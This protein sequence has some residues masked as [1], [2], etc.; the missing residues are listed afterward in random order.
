MHHLTLFRTITALA[1]M[2]VAGCS[3]HTPEEADSRAKDKTAHRASEPD[4]IPVIA[5]LHD[6]MYAWE[7]TPYEWGGTK[8][9][10]MDCSGFVW[11]TL[12]DRFNLPMKRVT[13]SQLIQMGK[14]I[15]P[16]RLQPGDLVFFRINRQMHVGFY[17]T[18][19][20]FLH[21][22]ASQGVMRSSLD[23]VYWKSV[24]LEAR[25]LPNEHGAQISFNYDEEHK[26][27]L[28]KN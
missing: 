13:T 15:D 22:S 23:N 8:L 9:S 6:Q 11:R 14:R 2:I 20:Y 17:D 24:F 21:A 25:R 1:L 28:A 18:E 4:L 7:G 16:D 19:R 27:V 10:G 3:S 5:A 12:K 26:R